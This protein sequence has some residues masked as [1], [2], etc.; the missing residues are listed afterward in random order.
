MKLLG[1]T[2]DTIDSDKDSKNVPSL[3]NVE[4]I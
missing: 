2:K 1:S 4:L 3:E